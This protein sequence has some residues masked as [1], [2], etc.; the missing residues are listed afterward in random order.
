[1]EFSTAFFLKSLPMLPIIQRCILMHYILLFNFA[2]LMVRILLGC[3]KF[4][5]KWPCP[6]CFIHK[7][8]IDCLGDKHD[9]SLHAQHSRTDD[10][11]WQSWIERVHEM[12]FAQGR[13]VISQAVERLIG[14]RSLV[15]THVRFLPTRYQKSNKYTFRILFLKGFHP[16]DLIFMLCSCQISCT[17]LSLECGRQHSLILRILYAYGHETIQALN[18]W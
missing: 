12:I 13:S 2:Y 5:G 15:P 6:C 1:M 4:L 3:M 16:L 10:H 14:E 8:Q 7:E 9:W 11:Q 17:S 18:A